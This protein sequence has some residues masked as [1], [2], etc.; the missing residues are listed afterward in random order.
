VTA[1]EPAPGAP[2]L[3]DDASLLRRLRAGEEAAF[4]DLVRRFGGRMRA[5]ARRILGDEHEA[6]DALQ[7]AVLSAFDALPGFEGKSSLGTWLHRIAVNSALGR[8]RTRK[9]RAEES[10][11]ALLPQWKEDG[12]HVAA[13]TEWRDPSEDPLVREELR[14]LVR[15]SVDRLPDGYREVLVLRDMEGWSTAQ[16]AE[17]LGIREEAAKV[18]LHRARQALRGLLDPHLR[19]EPA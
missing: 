4:E 1:A 14:G 12:H 10:I 9:R 16:T 2:S 15:A 6:D 13:W 19:K 11:D 18:R 5:V 17:A 8:L 7:E 3:A